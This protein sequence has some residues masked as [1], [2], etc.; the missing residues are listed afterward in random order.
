MVLPTLVAKKTVEQ[1]RRAILARKAKLSIAPGAELPGLESM[2]I[3]PRV[4]KLMTSISHQQLV[5]SA[6]SD[7]SFL[8]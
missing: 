7:M 8:I 3:C 4:W 2:E 5:K 6:P 1:P